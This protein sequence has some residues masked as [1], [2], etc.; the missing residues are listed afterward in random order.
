MLVM[1]GLL[2]DATRTDAEIADIYGMN[3]GTVA[4]VRRRMLDAG[5]IF[6]VNIPA[7]NK[8]GCEML[9]FHHGTT[10]PAI[11]S[12]IKASHYMDFCNTAPQIFNALIG[13]NSI[14]FF[15]AFKDA[16]DQ[17]QFLIAHNRFFTG[18]RRASKAKLTTTSFP[19]RISMGTYVT[20][21]APLVHNYFEL[22]V[23]KPKTRIATSEE[24]DEPDFTDSE[25]RTLI[26]LIEYPWA[27]DREIAA[28]ARLSRQ[29][30]TRIR[31]RL[32]ENGVITPAYLP[33]LYKWG[34]EICAIGH[35]KFNLE[36]NWDKRLKS[37]PRDVMD[38]AFFILSKPDEAVSS[39]MIPRF[40][41][42]AEKLDEILAWYHKA[43][44]LDERPDILLFS[45]E[46]CVELRTFEYAPA[47]RFLLDLG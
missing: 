15:T 9:S 21:F 4:S 10:D 45:L 12:D 33:R 27:T 35:A 32:I 8:L 30:V 23:P 11:S 43:R 2:E 19:Y 24:V 20:N 44:A 1:L 39:Y 25:K 16:T 41:E 7:F 14:A 5:A 28:K 22:D 18:T 29:A 40:Q 17:E 37:Q 46:R 31:H 13:G 42:Y 47:V 34:F 38:R 36:V 3:K 6:P 26:A